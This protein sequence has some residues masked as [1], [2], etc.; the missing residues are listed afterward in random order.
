MQKAI[1]IDRDGVIT[2]DV[3]HYYLYKPEDVLINP[4]VAESLIKFKK[5]GFL[6]IVIT[7]QGGIAR[8]TYGHED[9]AATHNK[10]RELLN[11]AGADYDEL[12]YCPHHDKVEK[13]L[14]RKP[15]NLN[16][17]K[18]ISRFNI[19]RAK[20]W[21]IGDNPRD[22]EAGNRSN[23]KGVLVEKNKDLLPICENILLQHDG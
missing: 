1:F 2:S 11:K 13:C 14:C 10:M 15:G 22:I 3:G 8:G 23:L 9:V 17:E 5:A 16:I 19:D 7:N 12:Y 18:A 4:G 20:S 21:M 6:I